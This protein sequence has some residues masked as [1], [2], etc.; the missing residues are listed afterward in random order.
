VITVSLDVLASI[1]ALLVA[2]LALATFMRATVTSAE[3][4]LGKR[5]DGV[6]T[7]LDRRI[8]DVETNLGKRIDDVESSL[9]KRIDSLDAKIDSIVANLGKRIDGVEVRLATLDDRVYTL[10]VGMRPLLETAEREVAVS[11]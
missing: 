3:V 4:R 2:T 1:G 6:E 5:I 8:D 9:D 7:R 10:A 11:R